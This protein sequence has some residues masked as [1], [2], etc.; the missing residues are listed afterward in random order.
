VAAGASEG[1]AEVELGRPV[2][3]SGPSASQKNRKE[4]G[5]RRRRLAEDSSTACWASQVRNPI[6]LT[7]AARHSGDLLPAAVVTR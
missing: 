3:S 4:H 6:S 5:R 2:P 1:G 7:Y